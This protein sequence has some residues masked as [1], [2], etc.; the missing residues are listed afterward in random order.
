MK[1]KIIVFLVGLLL[2]ISTGLLGGYFFYFAPP[3]SSSK[4]EVFTVGDEILQIGTIEKLYKE[5]FIKNT[6]GY[7]LMLLINEK[8]SK[9]KPGGYYLSKNMNAWQVAEELSKSPDMLWVT[10]PEGVRK[11]QIGEILAKTLNWTNEDLE[12]WN[13]IYTAMKFDYIEGVY[14][15][16]TYLIPVEENGLEIAVRMIN[17]FNEKFSPYFD[18][19]EEANIKWTTALKIASLLEREAAGKEDMPLIAGIIWNRLEKNMKLDIDATIQ[20]ARGKV[21]NSWWAPINP[22]D[23][24]EIDS[25]YNTYK[26]KGL[27]PGPI[28]NPGLDAIDAVLNSE[29][30]DCLYYLHDQN[31][32]IHCAK[33]YEEHKE[34]IKEFLQ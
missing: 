16:D 14:F 4:I 20:Y 26:Y 18:K 32:K 25:K 12:K 10:I 29:K 3:G 7:G 19:F 8:S 27:P 11:E 15:P 6:W 13:T 30:T 24:I 23:I 1:N 34:N 21:E 33:T 28:A 9:P 5:G 2:I 31:R 22:Q 17:R